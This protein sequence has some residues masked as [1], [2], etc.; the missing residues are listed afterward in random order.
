MPPE[1]NDSL[2]PDL[3]RLQTERQQLQTLLRALPDISFVLDAEGRYVQVIGGSNEAMYSDG[4]CLEGLTL[5]QA[6]PAEVADHFL[7]LVRETL[8]TGALQTVEYPLR[9]ADVQALPAEE[10]AS[11][12]GKADQWFEGRILPLPGFA[13]SQPVVL[14]VAVNIT[15]RKRM[16]DEL[17]RVANTDPLTGLP[18]RQ[19]L[20]DQASEELTRARRYA[21]PLTL[22]MIDV[23]RFK[24][25]NDTYGHA[26]GDQALREVARACLGQLRDT[27]H[28]GRVGGEE[29]VA[30]L[31]ETDSSGGGV[32]GERL[33]TAV[34]R[35]RPDSLPPELMVTIS[36]GGASLRQGEDL[37]SL[38]VRA[39]E[40]LYA[41]KAAGRN[42]LQRGETR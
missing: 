38:M 41:A 32:L 21:H 15:H 39:D 8:R 23:D 37:D 27:D 24:P 30:V 20:L 18:N 1:P 40:R 7:G 9:V 12:R 33:L 16:E 11:E 6:L 5:H 22:L 36:I 34:S 26:V 31:P 4:K 25:I 28:F 29:F 10:R 13:H 35:L 14:W 42:Q 17:R 3:V 19:H 2:D